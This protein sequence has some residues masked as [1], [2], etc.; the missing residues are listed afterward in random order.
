MHRKAILLAVFSLGIFVVLAS[1]L[2]RY[3]NFTEPYGSLVYLY[4]YAG[5]SSTAVMVANIPHCWPVVARMF[6]LSS[7]K[8]YGAS[9]GATPQYGNTGVESGTGG[10]NRRSRFGGRSTS[11]YT[12]NT[13]D[14][15]EDADSIERIVGK[16]VIIT[17]ANASSK[18]DL[19]TS[20]AMGVDVELGSITHAPATT[21]QSFSSPSSPPGYQ[22]RATADRSSVRIPNLRG[23]KQEGSTTTPH[24]G[25]VKT[26]EVDQKY[27]NE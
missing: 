18:D 1:I 23:H 16:D 19:A 3:Y 4:W 24:G 7:F 27:S 22:A 9:G 25:I 15:S 12:K 10:A 5:E 13:R 8:M 2:N 14:Q 26:I 21:A 6:R 17:T 11:G 20:H